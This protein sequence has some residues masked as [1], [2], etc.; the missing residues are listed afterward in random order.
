MEQ[1]YAHPDLEDRCSIAWLLERHNWTSPKAVVLVASTRET[2]EKIERETRFYITSLVLLAILLGPIGR[3]HRA[4]ENSLHW[5]ID[6][7]FRDDERR[8]RIDHP[9][10]NFTTVKH[11]ARNLIQKAPGKDAVRPSAKSPLGTTTSS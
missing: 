9:P 10:A 5:V 3:G 7:F 6:R 8:I 2:G 4:I 11:I 1:H